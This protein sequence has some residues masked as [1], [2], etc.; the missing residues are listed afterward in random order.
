MADRNDLI[1]KVSLWIAVVGFALP[2]SVAVLVLLIQPSGYLVAGAC[3]FVCSAVFF[4]LEVVALGCG[5][6]GRGTP[7]GRTGVIISGIFLAISAAALLYLVF[8]FL[9]KISAH[10]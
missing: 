2:A 7:A 8:G 4:V 1:G 9:L 5:I 6:A 10:G 3:L